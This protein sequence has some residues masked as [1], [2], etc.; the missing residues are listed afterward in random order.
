MIRNK[1][2]HVKTNVYMECLR[3]KI[4]D[5][6]EEFEVKAM[7]QQELNAANK[8]IVFNEEDG[9]DVEDMDYAMDHDDLGVMALL[10]LRNAPVQV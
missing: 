6:E 1:E 5:L 9:E 2:K 4:I 3:D 7:E 8:N 10:E